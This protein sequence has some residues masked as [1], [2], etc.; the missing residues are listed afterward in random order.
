MTLYDV[1]QPVKS[2]IDHSSETP[3]SLHQVLRSR[4]SP[5]AFVDRPVPP[6]IIRSILE[7]AQWAASSYNEQPW[8]FVLAAKQDVAAYDRLFQLLMPANQS[9]VKDVPV[10]LL[11]L[12][13]QT[14]SHNAA[15]NYYGM[16]DAG[17][18]L[19]QMAVQATA[20]GLHTHAMGGFDHQKARGVLDIPDDYSIGAMVAV[21]YPGSADQLD[22]PL[23]GRE[24]APRTRKP[25]DEIAF[26]GVWGQPLSL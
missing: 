19:A 25:L 21:G 14:F 26:G 2:N 12:A 11:T 1:Q 8:R 10:L 6:E 20:L 22:E 7:A 4:W 18:A 24:L 16:H 23:R 13:K 15:P 3:E 9:W 5:R 17:Q